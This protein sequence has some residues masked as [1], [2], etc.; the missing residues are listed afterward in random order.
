MDVW[1]G[2]V[3]QVVG[4][5]CLKSGGDDLRREVDLTASL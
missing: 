2:S 4:N 3:T 5:V 1:M